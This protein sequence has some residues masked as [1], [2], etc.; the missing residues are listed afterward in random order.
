[1]SAES[2]LPYVP[3]KRIANIMAALFIIWT[4]AMW[5]WV[6][7]RMMSASIVVSVT[8]DGGLVVALSP[9]MAIVTSILAML[10]VALGMAIKHLWDTASHD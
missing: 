5:T 2:P 6:I 9:A 8:D 10:N 4:L 1:M 3:K 7:D